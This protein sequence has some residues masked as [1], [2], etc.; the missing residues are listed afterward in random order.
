MK[1]LVTA[2]TVRHFKFTC[3]FFVPFSCC[4]LSAKVT[5][6]C[7]YGHFSL[8]QRVKMSR[9]NADRAV[10]F[11]VGVRCTSGELFNP[12]VSPT[13]K[14][15]Y[16]YTHTYIHIHACIYTHTW[17]RKQSKRG[18]MMIVKICMRTATRNSKV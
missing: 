10:Y 6:A 16:I 14:H 12:V 13:H 15:T 1:Q 18:G 8:P 9:Y 11:I 17:S 4:D 3:V 5:L 7:I 2:V